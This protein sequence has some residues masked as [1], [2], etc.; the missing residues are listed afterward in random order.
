MAGYD[1]RGHLLAVRGLRTRTQ[2]RWRAACDFADKSG[3]G[4][5][6]GVPA[7]ASPGAAARPGSRRRQCGLAGLRSYNE[8]IK[9]VTRSGNPKDM[10]LRSLSEMREAF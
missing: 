10:A 9:V 7:Y 4:P 5:L 3:S 1:F 6:H 2:A 8:G